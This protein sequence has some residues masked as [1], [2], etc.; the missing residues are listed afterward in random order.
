VTTLGRMEVCKWQL[1]ARRGER[2]AC[3]LRILCSTGLLFGKGKCVQLYRKQISPA[4]A[5]DIMYIRGGGGGGAGFMSS[6]E[7]L[8]KK[9]KI[10]Y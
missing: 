7:E 3:G 4:R 10:I 1:R 8:I 9:K 6:E 5:P 2:R